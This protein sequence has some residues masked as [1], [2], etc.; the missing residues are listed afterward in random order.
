MKS[1]ASRHRW[2]H[3]KV[4]QYFK[5]KFDSITLLFENQK[6]EATINIDKINNRLIRT[7]NLATQ[8]TNIQ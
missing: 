8:K 1:V 5:N 4:I 2:K 6:V 3:V 7:I